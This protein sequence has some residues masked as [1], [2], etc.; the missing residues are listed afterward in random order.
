MS[1]VIGARG[2][3]VRQAQETNRRT[4][5]EHIGQRINHSRVN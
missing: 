2:C 5:E 3:T 1:P 4:A